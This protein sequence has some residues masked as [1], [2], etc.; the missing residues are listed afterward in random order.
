MGPGP[1]GTFQGRGCSLVMSRWGLAMTEGSLDMTISGCST[2]GHTSGMQP[3]I[4]TT[5]HRWA[6][7]H[8]NAFQHI[9]SSNS[10]TALLLFLLLCSVTTNIEQPIHF[11]AASHSAQEPV[12]TVC[13]G[14]GVHVNQGPSCLGDIPQCRLKIEYWKSKSK[15]CLAL[16]VLHAIGL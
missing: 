14:F 3:S 10:I 16:A 12:F 2:P 5:H 6:N 11:C 13:K 8:K 1:I 4:F 9:F 15:S 7:S